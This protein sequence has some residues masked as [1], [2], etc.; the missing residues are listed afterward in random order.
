MASSVVG[1]DVAKMCFE[2]PQEELNKTFYS[3]ICTLTVKLATYEVF[4]EKKVDTIP[5]SE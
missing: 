1:Y 4:K 5:I 2:A 3:Q